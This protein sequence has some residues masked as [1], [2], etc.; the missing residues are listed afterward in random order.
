ML[1]YNLIENLLTSASDDYQAQPVNVRSYSLLG[2]FQRISA[3]YPGL[4]PTQI[5]S[6]V[7]EFFEKVTTITDNGIFLLRKNEAEIELVTIVENKSA[8]LIAVLPTNIHQGE[9][10]IELRTTFSGTV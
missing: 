1:Q 5:S 9:Y 6:A 8:R 3:R 2:I 10:F 7:N 4:A